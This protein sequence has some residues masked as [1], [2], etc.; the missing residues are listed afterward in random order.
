MAKILHHAMTNKLDLKCHNVFCKKITTLY[1]LFFGNPVNVIV[2]FN[3]LLSV[4]L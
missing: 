4:R 3:S 1:C 2:L